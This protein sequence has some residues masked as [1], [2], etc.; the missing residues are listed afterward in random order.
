MAPIRIALAGVG[1]Y[2]QRHLEVLRVL[3]KEGAVRLVATLEPNADANREVLDELADGGVGHYTDPDSLLK[4]EDLEALSIAAP[5]PWHAELV[6]AALEADCHVLVEKPPVVLVQ[7]LDRLV[8]LARDRERLVQTGY[9]QIFDETARDLRHALQGGQ[10]GAVRKLVV[11]GL[12]RRL[13]SYYE[14]SPWAGKARSE[15]RWTLDGPLN[16]ALTHFVHQALFFGA[17]ASREAARPLRVQAELYRAHPI[18][19]EDLLSARIWLDDEVEMLVYLTLCAPT[20]HVPRVEVLCEHARIEW[21]PGSVEIITEGAD[22]RIE[23]PEPDRDRLRDLFRN[24][25][26]GVTG[27]GELHNP[28]SA[29][30]NTIQLNNGCY[31]SAGGIQTVPGE[32]VHRYEVEDSVATEIRDLEETVRSAVIERKLFSELDIPWAAPSRMVELD[33]DRFDP[34]FLAPK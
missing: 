20:N 4:G 14:R 32:F 25:V 16:N 21:S 6:E 15:G 12:W 29:A 24:F 18:E 11:T 31:L 1:G 28:L 9:Q 26:G 10:Y 7:D 2:G 17:P 8:A 3:E 34:Q 23:H 27:Q 22:A 13:D 33:F 19:M 5:I 30:R